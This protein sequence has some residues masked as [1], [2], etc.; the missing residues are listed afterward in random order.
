LLLALLIAI[1]VEIVMVVI[2]VAMVTV[3]Y[4]VTRRSRRLTCAITS[5]TALIERNLIHLPSHLIRL[6]SLLVPIPTLVLLPLLVQRMMIPTNKIVVGLQ[7][8]LRAMVR[9]WGAYD[10]YP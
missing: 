1:V 7:G 6:L 2:V 5:V 4:V 9:I 8:Q 10:V 3:G